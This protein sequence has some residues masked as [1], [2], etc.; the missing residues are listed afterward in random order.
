MAPVSFLK[1][2]GHGTFESVGGGG[3]RFWTGMDHK[4][5]RGGGGV[6]RKQHC[7]EKVGRGGGGVYRSP[8]SLPSRP[9]SEPNN[10]KGE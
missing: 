2:K 8:A 5:V 9:S 10:D 1:L 7:K 6:R 4:S 3:A